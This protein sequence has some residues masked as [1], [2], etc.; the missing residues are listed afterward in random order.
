MKTISSKLEPIGLSLFI[1]GSFF[2]F[3]HWPLGTSLLTLAVFSISI[4]MLLE[5][6][7]TNSVDSI[8]S[9]YSLIIFVISSMFWIVNFPGAGMMKV[10]GITSLAMFFVFRLVK[11]FKIEMY[12]N[13]IL[14]ILVNTTFIF[15]C[16][17]FIFTYQSWP[18]RSILM[19]FTFLNLALCSTL[20][21]I[22]TM[23]K[24]KSDEIFM[25]VTSRNVTVLSIG[26]LIVFFNL[27]NKVPFSTQLTSFNECKVIQK[28]KSVLI[29][30]GNDLTKLISDSNSVDLVRKIN[31]LTD[32]Q[33]EE[34]QQI[35]M[36][37]LNE[38]SNDT[39]YHVYKSG[40]KVIDLSINFDNMN[41]P[42]NYDIPMHTFQI[43]RSPK[44]K[45]KGEQLYE[46][47]VNYKVNLFKTLKSVDNKSIKKHLEI[48][49]CKYVRYQNIELESIQSNFYFLNLE[50][51]NEYQLDNWIYYKFDHLILINA[52]E[53]MSEIERCILKS[54][55]EALLFLAKNKYDN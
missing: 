2:Y 29:K 50:I 42:F 55:V 14:S 46:N 54:R 19:V 40:N 26:L 22:L 5:T 51:T 8:G 45:S 31:D 44:G 21:Y 10:L 53:K 6:Q 9:N 11:S 33:L 7:R 15:L 20:F 3:M 13:K 41:D 16:I 4:G 43:K 52:L 36:N 23:G 30:R 12:W 28:E 25:M 39:I 37:M 1:I 38:T 17:S 48:I 47:L 49:D 18:F 35:K 24:I 32:V 27:L 34:L